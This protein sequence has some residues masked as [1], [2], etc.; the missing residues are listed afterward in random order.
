MDV[1]YPPSYRSAFGLVLALSWG[2]IMQT[3]ASSPSSGESFTPKLSETATSAISWSSI[4]GGVFVALAS[5][6]ALMILGSGLGFS[7]RSPWVDTESA[8][9]LAVAS[10]IWVILIQWIS[11]ALGGYIT[12]R[13]RTRW[14]NVHTHE[15]FFRDTAHGFVTWSVATVLTIALS[16]GV[17]SVGGLAGSIVAAHAAEG[18]SK[19]AEMNR[20]GAHSD[21]NP[22]PYYTD[23][24]FRGD[25]PATP[26]QDVRG[27]AGRIL[28]KGV[29]DNGVSDADKAYLTQLVQ[30]RTGIADSDA[31]KRVDDV[32]AQENA[33]ISK[34]KEVADNA[35]KTAAILSICMALALMIGAF[36]ASVSAALGGNIRDRHN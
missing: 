13:L 30:T 15:V 6:T 16:I 21:F 22:M 29:K 5:T 10:V 11:S 8:K 32:I 26:D 23:M 28:A 9:H 3:S 2:K 14:V 1:G 34:V 4:W 12:G 24:L 33:D 36:V 31:R 19:H 17:V 20:N 27:E 18:Y 25:H 7:V 35:R